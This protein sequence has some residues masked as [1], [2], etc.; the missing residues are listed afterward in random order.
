MREVKQFTS[1]QHLSYQG[2]HPKVPGFQSSGHILLSVT[3]VSPIF[4][5]ASILDINILLSDVPGSVTFMI[6]KYPNGTGSGKMHSLKPGDAMLFKTLQEFDYKPNQF[7]HM[8]FIAGGSGI[9][10]LYQLTRAVLNNPADK[11]KISLVYANNSEE[12]I[13]LRAE[14]DELASKYPERFQRIYTVSKLNPGSGGQVQQGY[15]TKQMLAQVMPHKLKESN[16]KVLVSG[17]P[18]MVEAIAGA[19]G[20]FGWTQGSIGGILGELG[21][22]KED[23]HKF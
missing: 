13:L 22:T 12:D 5:W 18:P 8:T 23:V 20:G 1:C 21:Y 16:T 2:T 10:P 15:V 11:T 17:P 4:N 9:T 7:S 3:M 6:K 19:K 14:F